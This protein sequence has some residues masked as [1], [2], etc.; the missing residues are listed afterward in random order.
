MNEKEI[1]LRNEKKANIALAFTSLVLAA[2]LLFTLILNL[3]GVAA[4]SF[5][6]DANLVVRIV[7]PILI[8]GL[9]FPACFVKSKLIQQKWFKYYIVIAFVVAMGFVGFMVPQEGIFLA[10]CIVASTLYFK[11]KITR[12]PC[13]DD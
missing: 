5:G 11:P 3:C 4:F 10:A 13:S 2:F 6:G 12:M 1:Y 9:V 8:V 7:L